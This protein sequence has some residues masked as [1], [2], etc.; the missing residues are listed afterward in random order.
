MAGTDDEFSPPK[1]PKLELPDDLAR[2]LE[3]SPAT[4]ERL[5]ALKPSPRLMQMLQQ[6]ARRN[7]PLTSDIRDMINLVLEKRREVHSLEA[8]LDDLIDRERWNP[9]TRAAPPP[10]APALE[11]PIAAPEPAVERLVPEIEGGART[12]GNRSGCSQAFR[13]CAATTTLRCCGF[14]AC[15]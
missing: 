14:D 11:L 10:S 4:V 6:L 13:W 15:N 12:A 3:L 8:W 2:R 5:Q 9:A 7:R 1:L